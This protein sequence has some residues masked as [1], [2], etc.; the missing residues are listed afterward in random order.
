[1]LVLKLVKESLFL[2]VL[3]AMLDRVD[4]VNV[5]CS[6]MG[7]KLQ[8][9]DTGH[10]TIIELFIPAKDFENYY[11]D[12][13]LCVGIPVDDMVKTIC[14]TD[15][16]DT[17]TIKV[18]D[19]NFNTITLSFESPKNSSTMACNLRVVD[20]N[21]DFLHIPEVLDSNYQAIV[22]MPSAEFMRICKYLSNIDGDGHIS[23]TEEGLMFFAFGGTG[24]VK[25]KCI[26]VH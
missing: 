5:D 1:M 12:E 11:C 10:I 22:Q 21:G 2:N 19:E 17:I 8:A 15:E 18:G 7:L 4:V 24:D 26:K 6:S 25:I 3:E 16:D 23:V 14:C 13:V 20:A 9:V